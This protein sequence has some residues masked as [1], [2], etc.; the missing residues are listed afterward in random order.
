MFIKSLLSLLRDFSKFILKYWKEIMFGISGG[1]RLA[2]TFFAWQIAK[3]LLYVKAI[4]DGTTQNVAEKHCSLFTLA[5][6]TVPIRIGKWHAGRVQDAIFLHKTSEK[7]FPPFFEVLENIH[8][9]K[10]LRILMN[11]WTMY[12]FSWGT[13]WAVAQF[14]KKVKVK[15]LTKTHFDSGKH[16]LLVVDYG[17]S[18]SIAFSSAF[19]NG[20]ASHLWSGKSGPFL[21]KSRM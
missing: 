1:M 4:I 3:N 12:S 9:N 16:H 5:A 7:K 13:Q 2:V 10:K 14:S 20:C 15:F 19:K 11:I 17:R 21:F 8:A 6:F 18:S